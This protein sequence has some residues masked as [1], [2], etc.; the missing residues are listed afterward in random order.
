MVRGH[1]LV[2][3]MASLLC[4][5]SAFAQT[6][7][8]KS[9]DEN[10]SGVQTTIGK[11]SDEQTYQD[12]V[13]QE[14]LS[15]E[16]RWVPLLLHNLGYGF[17]EAFTGSDEQRQKWVSQF[18]HDL[19]EAETGVLTP[20]QWRALTLRSNIS[21]TPH[22]TLPFGPYIRIDGDMAIA[23]GLLE[24]DQPQLFPDA[25]TLTTFTCYRDMGFCL[26]SDVWLYLSFA[27]GPIYNALAG[28][29]LEG[30]DYKLMLS[31]Q[32]LSITSW[33]ED[34]VIATTQDGCKVTTLTITSKEAF[35]T[36][37]Y[38]G[39]GNDPHCAVGAARIVKLIDAGKFSE[40]YYT[41]KE[42]EAESYYSKEYREYL[43]ATR[44]TIHS[45]NQ[46]PSSKGSFDPSPSPQ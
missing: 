17:R 45:A 42:K 4:I 21:R 43:E 19:G 34:E 40:D 20:S 18:Q 30:P 10:A 5:G 2:F 12:R 1:S 16:S 46:Q 13:W 37:R 33:N 44:R 28:P 27:Q 32:R 35:Q 11:S 15:K 22:I 7:I 9:S 6:T 31:P 36:Y 14:R 3:A 29:V 8:G 26:Q 39:S 41:E 38:G 25:T 23:E 24:G